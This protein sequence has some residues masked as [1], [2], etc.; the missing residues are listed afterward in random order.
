MSGIYI[1]IT[2]PNATPCYATAT[3]CHIL[4]IPPHIEHQVFDLL[5]I[6]IPDDFLSPLNVGLAFSFGQEKSHTPVE[7]PLSGYR[8]AEHDKVPG[9][10]TVG[11]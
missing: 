4:I 9:E 1:H 11:Y 6:Q 5:R 8:P 3:Q 10:E 2:P 7:C